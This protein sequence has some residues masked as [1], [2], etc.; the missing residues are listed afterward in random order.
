VVSV[1]GVGST[2]TLVLPVTAPKVAEE[3][4]TRADAR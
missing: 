3:G 1:V 2:F 4:H